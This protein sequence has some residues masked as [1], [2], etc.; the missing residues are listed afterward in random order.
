MLG[1]GIRG[2][3]LKRASNFGSKD[4]KSKLLGSKGEDLD[5]LEESGKNSYPGGIAS[6]RKRNTALKFKNSSLTA[7]I[8][9]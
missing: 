7:D 5:T 4:S 2:E 8:K 1:A 9:V 6:E 3:S